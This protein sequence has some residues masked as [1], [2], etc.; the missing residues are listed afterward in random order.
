MVIYTIKFKIHILAFP[1]LLIMTLLV[2]QIQI[3][4]G[5]GSTP[6]HLKF[7]KI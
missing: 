1:K 3:P 6:P 4:K 5:R 7:R 2:S